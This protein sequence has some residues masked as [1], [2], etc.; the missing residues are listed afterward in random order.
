MKS[1][2][3]RADESGDFPV[4][5][6]VKGSARQF[7]AVGATIEAAHPTRVAV[8]P[9]NGKAGRRSGTSGR[10][11]VAAEHRNTGSILGAAQRYHVFT[12]MRLAKY[13][14]G[15]IATDLPNVTGDNVSMSRVCMSQ[16][17]L[18]EIIPEL[19]AGNYEVISISCR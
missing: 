16:D 8:A 4:D 18:D 1:K 3:K 15:C 5:C 6:R 10:C 17:V 13:V 7:L 2:Y 12:E 14:A 11:R 9:V 19:I